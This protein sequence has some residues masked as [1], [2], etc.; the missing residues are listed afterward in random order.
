MMCLAVDDTTNPKDIVIVNTSFFIL[1]FYFTFRKINKFFQK[2]MWLSLC[3]KIND[4]FRI[5]EETSFLPPT[6]QC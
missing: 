4:N 2:K 5:T 1:F 6:L 3:D